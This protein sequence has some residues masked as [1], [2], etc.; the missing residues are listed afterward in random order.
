LVTNAGFSNGEMQILDLSG[1]PASGTFKLT[2]NG[3]STG[4][5]AWNASTATIYAALA[6]LPGLSAIVV[7]GSLAAQQLTFNLSA[8]PSIATLITVS[9]NSLETSAP[10]A[11]TFTE[12]TSVYTPTLSPSARNNQFVVTSANTN[13]V[14]G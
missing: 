6:A 12:D 9:A 8:V 2:Y 4:A 13:I 10:A 1:V 7:G 3:N 5:L 11:I 14:E